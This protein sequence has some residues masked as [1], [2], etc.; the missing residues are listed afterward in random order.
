MRYATLIARG[1]AAFALAACTQRVETT[2]AAD[3][4]ATAEANKPH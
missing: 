2:P 1:A 3:A 4:A